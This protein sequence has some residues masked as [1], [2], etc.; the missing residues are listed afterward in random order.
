MKFSLFST[1]SPKKIFQKVLRHVKN[2][3]IFALRFIVFSLYYLLVALPFNDSFN[4][5]FGQRYFL[6]RHTNS[7]QQSNTSLKN[8]LNIS[9]P[10]A[11]QNRINGEET[12]KGEKFNFEIQSKK[13]LFIFLENH[14]PRSLSALAADK[15]RI[16]GSPQQPENTSTSTPKIA[17]KQEPSEFDP[18]ISIE[19]SEFFCCWN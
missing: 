8:Q 5:F 9:V 15:S 4:F 6:H 11:E 7:Q 2:S 19:I 10:D 16:T 1:F 18:D 12:S 13:Y 3:K 17:R 14:S